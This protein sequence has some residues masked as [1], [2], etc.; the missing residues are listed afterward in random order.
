MFKQA[1]PKTRHI[2]YESKIFQSL[3]TGAIVLLLL[4]ASLK[5]HAFTMRQ[6]TPE[7]L[8]PNTVAAPIPIEDEEGQVD[9]LEFDDDFSV[10]V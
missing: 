9:E 2:T 8:E 1:E 7:L 3:L 5:S 4:L 6:I 10:L